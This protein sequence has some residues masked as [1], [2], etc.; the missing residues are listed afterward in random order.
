M[1]WY[2]DVP[3]QTRFL[4]GK[5]HRYAPNLPLLKIRWVLVEDLTNGRQ[6]CFSSTDPSSGKEETLCPP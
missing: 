4:T 1:N 5:G 3:R 2:G 6:E